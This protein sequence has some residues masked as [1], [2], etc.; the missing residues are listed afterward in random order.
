ME[1][2]KKKGPETVKRKQMK[3]D[4]VSTGTRDTAR[5]ATVP[6]STKRK[7][8][9]LTYLVNCVWKN[10]AKKGTEKLAGIGTRMDVPEKKTVPTSTK[11]PGNPERNTKD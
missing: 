4:H 6:M 7:T 11:K 10:H 5:K 3:M 8:V 9:K 1:H 2:L